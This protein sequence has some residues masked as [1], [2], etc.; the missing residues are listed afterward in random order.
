MKLNTY[1]FASRRLTNRGEVAPS[2][3][4]VFACVC[5]WVCT[6]SRLSIAVSMGSSRSAQRQRVAASSSS[7]RHCRAGA[8]AH[9]SLPPRRFA[10]LRR[11]T[12]GCHMSLRRL[13]CRR[14]TLGRL[15]LYTVA[16]PRRF[17]LAS[18]RCA[19]SPPAAQA[20]PTTP[21]STA[22]PSAPRR[23]LSDTMRPCR[24]ALRRRKL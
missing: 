7:T 3:R 16:S 14:L 5:V 22:L 12:L 20:P 13:A 6:T 10:P 21:V 23:C 18:L 8:L 2:S 15:A 9:R 11:L 24:L 1:G 19:A 17:A 4:W